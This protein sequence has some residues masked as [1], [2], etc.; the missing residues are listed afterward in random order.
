[1]AAQMD[2]KATRFS[3]SPVQASYL[4]MAG[5]WRWVAEQARWQDAVR[6]SPLKTLLAK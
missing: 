5:T 6:V 1:M 2:Q 4:A 3:A